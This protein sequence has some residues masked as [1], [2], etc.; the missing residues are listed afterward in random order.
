MRECHSAAQAPEAGFAS[1]LRNTARATAQ[2]TDQRTPCIKRCI[3]LPFMDIDVL[4][5]PHAEAVP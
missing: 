2:S 4:P 5:A 3:P 1:H